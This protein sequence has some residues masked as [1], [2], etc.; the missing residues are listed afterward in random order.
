MPGLPIYEFQEDHQLDGPAMAEPITRSADILPPSAG[1]DK[2]DVYVPGPADGVAHEALAAC[3][4]PVTPGGR[5]SEERARRH[6][7]RVGHP[8]LLDVNIQLV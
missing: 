5:R 4:E 8:A 7:L 2:R 3:V 6:F 1:A